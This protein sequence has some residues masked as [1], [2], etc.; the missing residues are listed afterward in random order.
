VKTAADAARMIFN[1]RL[2]AVVAA[3]FMLAVLVIL[4]DSMREWLLV[5]RGRKPATSTEEVFARRELF[6]AA[7]HVGGD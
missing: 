5:T 3:S 1:D 6:V 7:D 4:A 2:D